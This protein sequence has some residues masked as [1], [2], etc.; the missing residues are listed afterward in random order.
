MSTPLTDS[1]NALT[2]YAN[3][4]TG[5][6][7]TTLSDAV[8]TLASGYGGSSL[9]EVKHVTHLNANSKN[10]QIPF[11]GYGIYYIVAVPFVTPQDALNARLNDV[12]HSGAIMIWG[13]N[14]VR[15]FNSG[16]TFLYDMNGNNDYWSFNG[17]TFADEE[18]TSLS[19]TINNGSGNFL[20]NHD[21]YVLMSK[22]S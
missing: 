13:N 17:T 10:I 7:D 11:L 4:V 5:G 8:H 22:E 16:P 15:N 2:T 12:F 1:I 14:G 19:V 3:E 21:Y 18:K 20:G 9:V 6:S